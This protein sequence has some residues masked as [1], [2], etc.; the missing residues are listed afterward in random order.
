MMPLASQKAHVSSYSFLQF[1][2]CKLYQIF[3]QNLPRRVL[4]DRPDEGYSPYSLV[5]SHL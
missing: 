2:S 4:R 1:G 5:R 3:P